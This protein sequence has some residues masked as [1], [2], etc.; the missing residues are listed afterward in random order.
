MKPSYT[1]TIQKN[2]FGSERMVF[3]TYGNKA[4][5]LLN[6]F[7]REIESHKEREAKTPVK[8][9]QFYVEKN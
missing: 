1:V 9:D 2:T 8:L 5:Q 6:L 3:K 4:N 7:G